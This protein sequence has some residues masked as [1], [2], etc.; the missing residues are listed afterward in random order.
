MIIENS[1]E[2]RSFG[3]YASSTGLFLFLGGLLIA[4]FNSGGLFLAIIGAFIAFTKTCTIIDTEKRR[5]RH[6]DYIFGFFPFGKWVYIQDSMKL[7]LQKV[8]RGYT[9]YTR[10]NQPVDIKETDIRIFLFNSN[11]KPMMPI[12]RFPSYESAESE[13]G[14]LASLLN[15]KLL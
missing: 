7:G 1:L 13:L 12:K 9:A 3:P 5:I 8:R 15:V 6:A 11:N 4:Y 2:R 14:D 10:G